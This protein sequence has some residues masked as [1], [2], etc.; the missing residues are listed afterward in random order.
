[1]TLH[2]MKTQKTVVLVLYNGEIIIE[3]ET[4]LSINYMLYEA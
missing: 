2:Q 4:S 3:I 1:M